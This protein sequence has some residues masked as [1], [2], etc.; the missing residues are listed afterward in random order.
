MPLLGIELAKRV[1]PL[2]SCRMHIGNGANPK[3]TIPL[4]KIFF[5]EKTAPMKQYYYLNPDT[6]DFK[7]AVINAPTSSPGS[8]ILDNTSLVLLPTMDSVKDVFDLTQINT[9]P[10]KDDWY[11][12]KRYFRH[13]YYHYEVYSVSNASGK[14]VALLATRL[15]E[16]NGGKALR[17]L[18]YIGDHKPFSGLGYELYRLLQ[19]K[20]CEYVDFITHGFDENAILQAGFS[21]RTNKDTNI[22]PNY[23]EPFV[24]ENVDIWVHYQT[25]G[26]LFF[27][28]DGDQDRPNI[29]RERRQ[30]EL[31]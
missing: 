18:D 1:V 8:V 11:F 17:I 7:I 5:R 12:E 28:A 22:I 16:A 15:I 25:D 3:T 10:Y 4:R 20:K 19:A 24:R 6:T 23:F 26:T 31:G 27:K 29:Y 14:T 30:Y 21:L 13:P 2:T 9:L